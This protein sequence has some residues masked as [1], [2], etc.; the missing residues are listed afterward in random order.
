MTKKYLVHCWASK[1][2]SVKK[3]KKY[4]AVQPRSEHDNM[5]NERRRQPNTGQK[6]KRRTQWQIQVIA[7][8]ELIPTHIFMYANCCLHALYVYTW[9]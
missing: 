4:S 1:L 5:M 2:A 8:Q 3:T 7:T 6:N 9:L